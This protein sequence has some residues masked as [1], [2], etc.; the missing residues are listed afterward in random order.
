VSGQ[1]FYAMEVANGPAIVSW[2]AFSA[3]GRRLYGGI[4]RPAGYDHCVTGGEVIR[5]ILRRS[6]TSADE[7][8]RRIG[9]TEADVA[10]WLRDDPPLSVVYSAAS[11]CSLE[12]SAV[13]AEPEPDPHD[14]SLLE[15]TAAM[16][17]DERL[18]R[19]KAYVRFVQAGRV[20]LGYEP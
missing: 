13:L 8:A 10:G 3:A 5:R 14:I 7:L 4:G 6:G 17:V 20:A 12:L 15:T 11:A 1:K 9:V 16:T 18:E 2:G 19:L